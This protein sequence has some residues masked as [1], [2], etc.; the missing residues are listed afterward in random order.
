MPKG[1]FDD[2]LDQITSGLFD[3]AN[4]TVQRKKK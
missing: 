3:I 2:L 4:T 1:A